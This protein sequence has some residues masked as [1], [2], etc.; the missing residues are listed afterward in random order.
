IKCYELLYMLY[1]RYL[2]SYIFFTLDFFSSLYYIHIIFNVFFYFRKIIVI[3]T[4]FEFIHLILKNNIF[5]SA[6]TNFIILFL[7]GK[8]I[9]FNKKNRRWITIEYF[10]NKFILKMF[11]YLS[12]EITFIYGKIYLYLSEIANNIYSIL[13]CCISGL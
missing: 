8:F 12:D 11:T 1:G 10:Y 7:G 5:L 9:H 4:I 3:Y 6:G 13:F 2:T